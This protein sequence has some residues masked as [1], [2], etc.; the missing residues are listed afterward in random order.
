M[1]HMRRQHSGEKKAVTKQKEMAVYQALQNADIQFEYQ[2]YIPFAQCGLGSE[3]KCAYADFVIYTAGG[4]I[5]LECDEDQHRSYD[6]SCDVRRDFDIAASVALGSQ[7]KLKIVHYNPDA[8]RVDGKTKPTPQKDRLKKLLE[9]LQ[10]EP[11]TFERVFLFYDCETGAILPQ[12]AAS[13]DA[14]ARLVSRVA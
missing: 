2:K 4:C 6:V 13:W 9:V 14:I 5:I 8:Y 11:Q 1:I 7:H 12:V 3:T 10:E